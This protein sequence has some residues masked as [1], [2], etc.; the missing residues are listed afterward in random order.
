MSAVIPGCPFCNGTFSARNGIVLGR[1]IE[2]PVPSW[3]HCETC[4]YEEATEPLTRSDVKELIVGFFR[5]RKVVDDADR[6]RGAG[7]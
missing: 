2:Y 7:Q 6:L 5:D 4:G 3:V 1:P